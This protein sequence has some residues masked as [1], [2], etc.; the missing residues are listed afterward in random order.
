[1]RQPSPGPVFRNN[2]GGWALGA[3]QA[4]PQ[5]PTLGL[6]AG[7]LGPWGRAQQCLGRQESPGLALGAEAQKG[8]GQSGLALGGHSAWGQGGQESGAGPW[9]FPLCGVIPRDSLACG[10]GGAQRALLKQGARTWVWDRC[11]PGGV[12]PSWAIARPA[13]VGSHSLPQ[14][15]RTWGPCQLTPPAAV[16]LG[17]AA[18]YTCQSPWQHAACWAGAQA[19]RSIQGQRSRYAGPGVLSL[20]APPG[21]WPGAGGPASG[22]ACPSPSIPGKEQFPESSRADAGGLGASGPSLLLASAGPH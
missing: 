11:G 10:E 18:W 5:E 14:P 21:A 20:V 6:G 3:G 17:H 2:A 22:Q 19:G 12:P 8:A 15:A 13:R 7:E 4:G 16:L 9:G 1:M